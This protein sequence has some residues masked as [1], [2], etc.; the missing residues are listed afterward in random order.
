M[1]LIYGNS[2][3]IYMAIYIMAKNDS[4][5]VPKLIFLCCVGFN[6]NVTSRSIELAV[7]FQN[8]LL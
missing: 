2:F 8:I 5:L 3:S 6:L 4:L 7:T 1:I